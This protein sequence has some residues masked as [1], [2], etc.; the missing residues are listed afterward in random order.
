MTLRNVSRRALDLTIEPGS[1]DAADIDVESHPRREAPARRARSGRRRGDGAAAA[2]R[3][4]GAR[5]AR[6]RV[7]MKGGATLQIPWTIVGPAAKQDLIPSARLS[8][9]PSHRRDVDPAVLTVVAG[10]RRRERRAP[11]APAARGARPSTSTAATASSGGSRSSATCS[12]GATRS[13][14][15]AAGRAGRRLPPGR[16]RAAL[17]ADP[18]GGGASDEEVGSVHDRRESLTVL[19]LAHRPDGQGIVGAS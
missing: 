19:R 14:S 15:P 1:A 7:K 16:I 5:M 12:R 11:A 9:G 4:G 8:S 18:V 6:L 10:R 2:A 17:D 13:G 3:A